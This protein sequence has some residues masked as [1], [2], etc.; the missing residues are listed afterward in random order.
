MCYAGV[1]ST[2]SAFEILGQHRYVRAQAASNMAWAA[3]N[4]SIAGNLDPPSPSS[5]SNPIVEADMDAPY[6]LILRE[7]LLQNLP[8]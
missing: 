8:R 2:R 1:A 4:V 5:P 6:S 3:F 7:L